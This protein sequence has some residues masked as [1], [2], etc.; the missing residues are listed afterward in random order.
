VQVI[1]LDPEAH[2]YARTGYTHYKS[3]QQRAAEEAA[4][5]AHEAL[6]AALTD[7]QEI[8]EQF[9]VQTY[10]NVKAAK[11]LLVD[12]LRVAVSAPQVLGR[13]DGELVR[14]LA[15][16]DILDTAD[17][18]QDRLVRLL[19]AQWIAGEEDHLTWLGQLRPGRPRPNAARAVAW[20][21][22]LVAA[23]YTLSP[24]ETELR[25]EL[26]AIPDTN[27]EDQVDDPG[28]AEVPRF[29]LLHSETDGWVLIDDGSGEALTVLDAPPDAIE[30]A[31]TWAAGVLG[32][33]GHQVT[34]W[35]SEPDGGAEVNPDGR[36]YH[37]T[38]VPTSHG[39]EASAEPAEA[40]SSSTASQDSAG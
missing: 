39:D 17:A 33:L 14:A 35:T 21:D 11:A 16:G 12:A 4:Q 9:L 25:D 15:G 1:C 36:I 13:G 30:G 10:G 20:L 27:E 32:D 3:P 37:A 24:V 38:L 40:A 19:V 28:A 26:A 5:R 18:K 29:A 7:A 34:G 8:R 6:V 23:G 2:G 31:Q 22:R